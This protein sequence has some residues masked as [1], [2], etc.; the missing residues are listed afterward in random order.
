MNLLKF[1]KMQVSLNLEAEYLIRGGGGFFV[2][3]LSLYFFFSTPSL[4]VQFFSDLIKSKQ[5]SSQRVKHE[6][7]F[8]PFFSFDSPYT[9]LS[10]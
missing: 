9:I 8:S 1:G 5:F 7:I 3:K 2:I 10:S 6:T 4:N